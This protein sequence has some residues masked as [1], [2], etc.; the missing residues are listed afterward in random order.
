MASKAQMAIKV[1]DRKLKERRIALDASIQKD[2]TK[3]NEDASAQRL[4]AESLAQF[5]LES[6]GY[7]FDKQ[8]KWNKNV[9]VNLKNDDWNETGTHKQMRKDHDKL[10]AKAQRLIDEISLTGIDPAI[11]E[12]INQLFGG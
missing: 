12:R 5:Y 11:I 9:S 2:K 6:L 4:E 7:R 3:F 1:I 8:P 10:V